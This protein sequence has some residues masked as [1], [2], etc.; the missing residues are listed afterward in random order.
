M[1]AGSCT[2]MATR[3]S[4]RAGSS[5]QQTGLSSLLL[6]PRYHCMEPGGPVYINEVI[7]TLN[8]LYSCHILL[9]ITAKSC[10]LSSK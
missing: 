4:T 2:G 3:T 9:K 1:L 6:S 10:L 5:G 8:L 7:Y